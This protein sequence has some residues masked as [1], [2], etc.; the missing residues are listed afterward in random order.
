MT[1]KFITKIVLNH[2][3]SQALY[4]YADGH[5]DLNEFMREVTVFRTLT[6]PEEISPVFSNPDL[7]SG[8]HAWLSI[9]QSGE[10]LLYEFS[11]EP[12]HDWRKVTVAYASPGPYLE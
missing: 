1:S 9:N 7:E 4:I 8:C 12:K 11:N 5:I 3:G 6:S 2:N 10:K